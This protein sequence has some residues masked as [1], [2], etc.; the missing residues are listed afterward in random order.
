MKKVI[1]KIVLAGLV[2]GTSLVADS[3]SVFDNGI[4]LI[5]I[6]GGI[7]TMK[8]ELESSPAV[9][10]DY[11]VPN[12][13]LKVGAEYGS[14]RV[15]LSG[16]YFS[17]SDFDYITTFGV[18]GQYLFHVSDAA[19]IFI[20]VNAGIA[21]MKFLVDGESSSRSISDPY[22]GGD[23]GVNF[24]VNEKFDLEL[25]ARV[26]NLVSENSMNGVTYKFDNIVSGY[27]SLIYKFQMD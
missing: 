27:A 22:V 16:R 14:Y 19:N 13:G 1:S 9:K 7:G 5:G 25:G 24:H 26:M 6:E 10:K 23:A 11:S 3:S 20:G 15:F 2:A 17:Q 8:T 4:S 18:E 21:N 12:I